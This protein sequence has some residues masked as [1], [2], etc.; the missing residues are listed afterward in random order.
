MCRTLSELSDFAYERDWWGWNAPE[1]RS[2]HMA[3]ACPCGDHY[4]LVSDTDDD[5]DLYARAAADIE[6]CPGEGGGP[7]PQ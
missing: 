3:F 7:D 4:L 6:S 1:G 2:Q 5:P